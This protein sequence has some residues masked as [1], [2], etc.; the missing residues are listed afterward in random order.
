LIIEVDVDIKVELPKIHIGVPGVVFREEYKI[1]DWI[2]GTEGG[3]AA[4]MGG[5]AR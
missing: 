3:G 1:V 2:R 5:C 4:R